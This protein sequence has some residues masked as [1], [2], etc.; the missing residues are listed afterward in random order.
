[1]SVN[2][3]QDSIHQH[4]DSTKLSYELG[5]MTTRPGSIVY[6]LFFI[7]NSILLLPSCILIFSQD[8]QQWWRQSTASSAAAVQK[9]RDVFNTYY[10]LTELL[11]ILAQVMCCCGIYT[12]SVVL[13]VGYYIWCFVWFGEVSFHV[14]ACLE[15]YLAVVHPVIFRRL[16]GKRGFM[17]KNTILSSVWLFCI[18]GTALVSLEDV[19]SHFSLSFILFIFVVIAIFSLSVLCTL[20][21][22]VPGQ[23]GGGKR[24]KVDQSKL[25]AFYTI[26]AILGSEFL[27]IISNT[28][29][30]IFSASTHPGRCLVM[31]TGLWFCIPSGQVLPFLILQKAGKITCGK[32]STK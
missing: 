6:T 2:Y 23:H 26:L 17:I 18:V 30:A 28:L 15:R 16:K 1:M 4:N 13:Q 7:I 32:Q 12:N 29:W 19:F 11:T 31:M 27:K 21:H 14:L 3:S 9:P 10:A 5:C 25:M 20:I 24:G 8:L 22:L